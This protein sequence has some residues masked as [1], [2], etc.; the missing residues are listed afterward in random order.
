MIDRL[1]EIDNPTVPVT[2]SKY[3]LPAEKKGKG[4]GDGGTEANGGRASNA[5]VGE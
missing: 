5:H 3:S 1:G 4:K 2:P